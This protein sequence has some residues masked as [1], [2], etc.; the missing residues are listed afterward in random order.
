[1]KLSKTCLRSCPLYAQGPTMALYCFS[2]WSKLLCLAT[3]VLC[4][5]LSLS[6][7]LLTACCFPFLTHIHTHTQE[8]AHTLLHWNKGVSFTLLL[9][10]YA[11]S[12][13]QT[14][15]CSCLNRVKCVCSP[16][17][18]M[19]HILHNLCN[20]PWCCVWILLLLTSFTQFDC[21]YI[22]CHAVKHLW[23]VFVRSW[24]PENTS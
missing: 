1:M 14:D 13:L 9:T 15:L 24:G 4:K 2:Y 21:I 20:L 6:L 17:I 3:K 23:C 16:F 18:H 12:H 19:V 22:L 11:C 10:Q 5:V 7:V 8:C